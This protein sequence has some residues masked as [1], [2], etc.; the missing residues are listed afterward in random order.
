MTLLPELPQAIDAEKAVLGS[1]LLN[2]DAIFAVA[3]DLEA[4]HFHY[5][6][7]AL[8]YA[9]MLAL[10]ARR[11]PTDTRL[12]AEELAARGQLDSIGGVAY[13]SELVD[14]VPTAYHVAY[15]A[16]PVIRAAELRRLI[17]AG[18]A[19]AAL[20][21]NEADVNDARAQA[22]T[23]L[24]QAIGGARANEVAGASDVMDA[25]WDD[26]NREDEPAV[27][28]GFF[29]LDELLGGFYPGEFII[30]GARPSVGKTALAL[31]LLANICGSRTP[32]PLLFV[33]LE[34]QKAE[35]GRRLAAMDSGLDLRALRMR[36]ITMEQRERFVASYGKLGSW[37]YFVADKSDQTPAALRAIVMR[38]AAEHPRMLV[39]V[40]Y[41]GL[42]T[43]GKRTSN[44]QEEVSD[45]SRQLKKIAGDAG[46]PLIGLSQLNRAS[47]TRP[48]QRPMMAELRESG[49]LEQD[50]DVVMLLHR[51]HLEQENGTRVRAT[52]TQLLIEK[53]RN[54][55]TGVVNLLFQ[56]ETTRFV[57][58]EKYHGVH[59]YE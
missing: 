6:R 33:S 12:V 24:T 58:P 45:I 18:G 34:M 28:S 20:G 40:D 41:I 44:R 10:F 35:I 39:V 53:A 26:L 50:A 36:R 52:E 25:V 16:E 38:M 19:I 48:N 14:S 55:P 47:E 11:V 13:L 30:V 32:T 51:P 4:A 22:Q 56:P 43:S 2:R 21:Y 17:D 29:D 59:G 1:C 3:A 37:P 7:H 57:T 46:V 49:S 31:S 15:Y 9:A 54:G 27:A 5:E 42:M 23:V 8:I